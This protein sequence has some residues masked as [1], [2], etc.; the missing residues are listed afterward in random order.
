MARAP[1]AVGHAVWRMVTLAL[2]II[3]HDRP[4]ELRAALASARG[5][6]WDEV[7]VVDMASDPPLEPIHGVRWIRSDANVGVAAGRN[8]LTAATT[9]DVL[10]FLDDDA[11]IRAPV[12][13]VVRSRMA[14]DA[15]IGILAFRV[16]R[17]DGSM[18]RQEFP[19]RGTVREPTCGAAAPTSSARLRREAGGARRCRWI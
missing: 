2:C 10:V 19:F 1:G 5:E 8:M 3:C 18:A 13:R 15:R 7:A 4:D 11:V 14:S 6:T 9:A 16:V 12:G 17:P